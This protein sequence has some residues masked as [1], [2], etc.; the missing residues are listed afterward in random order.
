MEGNN[1]YPNAANLNAN[2][3]FPYFIRSATNQMFSAGDVD[4]GV[5]HWHEDLQFI[6]VLEGTVCVKTLEEE[7]ILSTG[8]GIFTNKNVIHYSVCRSNPCRYQLFRIPE[9]FVS[10]YMGSPAEKLT[11]AITDNPKISLIPLFPSVEW[12]AEALLLLQRLVRLEDEKEEN[13]LYPYDVLTELARLWRIFLRNVKIPEHLP[14]NIV[15]LRMKNILEFI[16]SHYAEEVTLEDLAAS[17]G[18]S[19]TEALRC[20]RQTLRTTPYRYMLEY[21]LSKAADLLAETDLPIGEIA[22]LAGFHQQS[23]FGKRFKEKTGMSPGNFRRDM[24]EK[25]KNTTIPSDFS[26]RQ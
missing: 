9:R 24:L 15:S 16:E 19:K 8:E 4:F 6:Y 11:R 20:F 14:K 7:E 1:S 18:V 2:T 3:E 13:P 10:F 17:A 12:R 25:A 5:L 26:D 23:Y 21:R 22:G